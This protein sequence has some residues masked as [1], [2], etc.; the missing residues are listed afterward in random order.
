VKS[1]ALELILLVFL[2]LTAQGQNQIVYDDALENGWQNYGWATL[3]YTN[4]SPVHSGSDSISVVDPGSSYQAIYLGHSAF[5]SSPYQ[6]ITFWIYP[7]VA[8]TNELLVQATLNGNA[9]TGV[10]LSFTAAQVNQWQQVTIPLSNLGVAN[11]ANFTGFWIQNQT[12]GPLTFY[13]DDISLVAAAIPNPVPLT[14]NAQS[15][16]RT[17]DSRIYG[18]NLAIWDSLLQ[19]AATST[20]VNTMQTGAFRFPG[21]SASDDYDWSTDRSVSNG[22]FQWV[23]NAATFAGVTQSANAQAYVTVNYGSGTPQQAAAWVAY[24]NGSSSTNTLAL[25]TDAK[26]RNWNT[27]GFWATLRASAP[28]ATDDGY[29]F[30]RISHP[31]P[32]AIHYWEIGN[33][34]YG[35]WENDLHGVSGSGLTG[36]RWDPYTYAQYFQSFY[37]AMLA[38]D[39]T[40]HI[41]AVATPGED[42]YNGGT[43]SVPN[44]NEGNSLHSGWTAVM[45]A[46][47]HSFGV[48]PHFIIDH[49]YPQNPGGESDAVL[50]QAGTAS[51]SDAA[52]I[53]KMITDYVGGTAGASIELA[54]TELNSVSSG[55]GKQTTSLV[56]GLFMADALG[57]LA[58]TEFNTCLWW[59]LRNGG[60]T[61]EN[62]SSSLYGWRQYGDYGVVSSGDISG[63]PANTPFPAF[64]AA[65]LLTNW[66]RGGDRVVTATSGYPLLTI[67]AAKLLD[68]NL[69][70]LV[71]NKHPSMDLPAQI[72]LN[73]FTPGSTS[74]SVISY[75]KPNDLVSGDLTTGTASASS[76][77]ISY[78]FPSYSMS[79][80][81]VKGQFEAWR[82]ANFNA[83]QLSNWSLSGDT[84]EPA[85]DGIPNLLKYAL[86]LNASTPSASGLPVIGNT[87]TS[88]KTYL[89]LSFTDL[90]A[91]TDITYTVQVSSDLKTWLSGSQY[92]LRT[93]NGSTNTATFRDLT[94]VQDAPRR[95]MRLSVTRP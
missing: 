62:N 17:I 90:S 64:Y 38:V 45:L 68:G 16:V 15:I 83:S 33:E 82:E 35:S 3:N 42:S 43:H 44:P 92:T 46:T 37:T 66:G 91:L 77:T 80:L 29:N 8:K 65:K 2:A 94:A 63:V 4:T 36:A 56:N 70:L 93:D 47:L 69:A 24:Y 95:F 61:G 76:G 78:T 18:I 25:G 50:L 10:F 67:Y 53:R 58:S 89:T 11:N 86:G 55:P 51:A 6:S 74:V 21:G 88:G 73:N 87:T 34:C 31:A 30:L 23:N 22:S 79:V 72:A 12:G 5:N 84:G 13:V 81:V 20:V 85:G 14:V 41:G 27:V 60:D 48:T 49:I 32:F 54:V 19:G 57:Q 75:G 39:P 59:D 52:N 71:V 1:F 7:T 40:V 28:L 9:Q 26:G